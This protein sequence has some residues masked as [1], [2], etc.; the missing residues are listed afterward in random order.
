MLIWTHIRGY[1]D[2]DIFEADTTSQARY[3]LETVLSHLPKV[4]GSENDMQYYV[5]PK[6]GYSGDSSTDEFGQFSNLVEGH[7]LDFNMQSEYIIAVEGDLR[8]RYFDETLKEFMKRICR[9][10]KRIA[11]CNVVV[12][13]YRDYDKSITISES[14]KFFDMKEEPSWLT[15]DGLGEPAWT[16]YLLPE[17]MKIVNI[18]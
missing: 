17:N 3:I 4:T 8:D 6:N 13:I 5:I 16:E 18:Q 10:A 9:F 12:H 1:I 7:C 15:E 2:V 14:H 11:V